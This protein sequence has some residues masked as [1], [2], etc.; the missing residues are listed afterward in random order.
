MIFF[1]NVYYFFLYTKYMFMYIDGCLP[2]IYF[3]NSH[4]A[5]LLTYVIFYLLMHPFS[6]YNLHGNHFLSLS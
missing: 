6:L 3:P 2:Q 4:P 1:F 5:F